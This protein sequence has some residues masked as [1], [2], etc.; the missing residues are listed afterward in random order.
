MSNIQLVVVGDE[1][2]GRSIIWQPQKHN[3]ALTKP[4]YR[5]LMSA[6]GNMN[7]ALRLMNGMNAGGREGLTEAN[8]IVALRLVNLF[9]RWLDHSR[10]GVLEVQDKKENWTA[11]GIPW[12]QWEQLFQA[13]EFGVFD[14]ELEEGMDFALNVRTGP[15]R[16]P[17]FRA[18][19]GG[20]RAALDAMIKQQS[21]IG[22]A[23]AAHNQEEPTEPQ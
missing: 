4:Q 3:M 18:M 1:G 12:S 7:L 6:F 14:T 22:D 21:K 9:A 17:K 19:D 11:T 13:W 2:V 15:G 16:P 10:I 23:M 8:R 5:S 20:E